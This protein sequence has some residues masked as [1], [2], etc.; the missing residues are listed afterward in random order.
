MTLVLGP[1]LAIAYFVRVL[2]N[3][4]KIAKLLADK[5]IGLDLGFLPGFEEPLGRSA[6]CFGFGPLAFFLAILIRPFGALFSR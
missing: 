2:N 4:S 6:G 5:R 1:D 3:P